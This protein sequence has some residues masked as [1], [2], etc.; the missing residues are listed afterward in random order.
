MDFL[1]ALGALGA[2][3]KRVSAVHM[4]ADVRARFSPVVLD[5]L[6]A[7]FHGYGFQLT[8]RRKSGWEAGR[9]RGGKLKNA[10]RKSLFARFPTY[11]TTQT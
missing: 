5:R 9:K 4:S 1:V 11:L 10:L 8:G 7:E 2:D 3:G 6:A